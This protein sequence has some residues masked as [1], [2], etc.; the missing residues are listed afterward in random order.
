MSATARVAGVI[1]AR[2]RRRLGQGGVRLL[3]GV[4]LIGLILYGQSLFGAL[5]AG[6]RLDPALRDPNGPV[7]VVVTLDFPPERFHSERLASYGMFAG[8]A[9]SVSRIRLRG[10]TPEALAQLSRIPWVGRIEPAA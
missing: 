8:R 3:C 7:N 1:E 6:S 10:V 9:G 2:R 4:L 5:T